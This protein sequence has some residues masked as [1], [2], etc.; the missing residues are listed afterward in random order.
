M[1]NIT[2][3]AAEQILKSFENNNS[4]SV[5]VSTVLRIAV[6]EKPDG[7]FHYIMGLDEAKNT[8][9]QFISN[10]VKIAVTPEHLA[11]MDKMEIDYIEIKPTEFNFIFKNPNDPNYKQPNE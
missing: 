10:D 1:I 5:E 8:D 7:G 11:L 2:P 3:A 6:Q 9:T 4:S